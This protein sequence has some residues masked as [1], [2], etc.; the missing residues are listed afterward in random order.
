VANNNLP[1]SADQK[2]YAAKEPL[3]FRGTKEGRKN[4]PPA[5]TFKQKRDVGTT[6]SD[7]YYKSMPTPGQPAVREG[8]KAEP[9]KAPKAVEVTASEKATLIDVVAAVM[10]GAT[11]ITVKGDGPAIIKA[12]AAVDMAVGRKTLTREQ[13]NM[14]SFNIE[15]LAALTKPPAAKKVTVKKPTKKKVTKKK[16]D[17]PDNTDSPDV[18]GETANAVVGDEA[19]AIL[20]PTEDTPAEPA[21]AR[22]E[23]TEGDIA[24]AFGVTAHVAAEDDPSDD[25]SDDS[26]DSDD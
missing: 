9:L 15:R 10:N 17:S 14:V 16:A 18:R 19:D 26:D 6:S 21:A 12:R 7:K 2:Y 5:P 13:A 11:S 22:D 3:L 8:L 20:N 25:D 24:E 1:Q 4:P 23:I